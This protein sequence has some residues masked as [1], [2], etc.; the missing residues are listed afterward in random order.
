[1]MADTGNKKYNVTESAY[2]ILKIL[3]GETLTDDTPNTIPGELPPIENSLSDI[4]ELMADSLAGKTFSL[5]SA[6]TNEFG[7]IY[8]WTGTVTLTGLPNTSYTKI[9]GS[10]HNEAFSSGVTCQP[11]QDRMVLTKSGYYFVDWQ[12]T[13]IGSSDVTYAIEPYHSALGIPQAVSAVRPSASG[14]ATSL[15]GHGVFLATGTSEIIDLRIFPGTNSVWAKMQ[16]GQLRVYRVKE[17]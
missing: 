5:P 11:L 15:S 9:T 12:V 13:L 3:C 8:T 2:R 6:A 17:F 1:M 7:E 14:S 16:A 10:F 4:A